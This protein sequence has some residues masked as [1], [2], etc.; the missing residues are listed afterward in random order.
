MEAD[1]DYIC[2][3]RQDRIIAEQVRH[4]HQ[5]RLEWVAHWLHQFG[6]TF[7]E[8][9][10]YLACEIPFLANRGGEAC[11]TRRRLRPGSRRHRDARPLD[12]GAQTGARVCRRFLTRP[13]RAPRRRPRAGH[14]P[15]DA[16]APGPSMPSPGR[17]TVRTPV[18]PGLRP[19]PAAADPSAI[20]AGIDAPSG[21]GQGGP[22]QGGPDPWATVKTR[23]RDVLLR[24]E[25][26][27]DQILVLPPSRA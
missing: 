15:P 10:N 26:W 19:G 2:A 21:A 8:L 25:L 16:L 7:D 13:R 24:T 18:F 22:G 6:W 3:T 1:L 9:P 5:G 27:S 4:E 12:R 20:S 17:R 23:M 14:Q 11:G